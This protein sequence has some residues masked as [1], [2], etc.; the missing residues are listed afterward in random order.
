MKK[1]SL[2]CTLD[3]FD[4]CKFNVYVDEN[5]VIKIEGDKE[6]PYT[7]GFICK[8][9]LMH[10]DRTNHSER[11]YSP[12]L[13]VDGKWQ[14]ISFN[15]AIELMAQKLGM[16]KEAYGSKSILYYEQ[17]GSGSVLKSI[18]DVFFNFFGGVSKQKGGPCWSAGIAAQN[19]NFGDVRSHA[20]EDML[21]S[22]TIIVWGKNP[23]HTTIH[24]MQMIKKAKQQGSYVIVIDPI[25]TAT[26]TQADKYIRIKAGGDGALALAMAKKII[27]KNLYNKEYIS[28]YVNG[29][30]AYRDYV[31]TFNMEKL[32]E[33]AGVTEAE[34][35]FL[36]EKY[37]DF[38]ATILLGYGLQKYAYGGNTIWLIDALA[39][40]TGQIG[41]S[42]GGVN[43]ANKVYP[44]VLNLDPYNSESY[45]D[46]RA[47]YVSHISDFIR[48]NAIKMAV[49]TKSNLLNQLPDLRSLEEAL[50][51]IEF[52]VCFDLFLTDTAQVCDL[53][54]PTTTVLESED[55]L[56]SSM[57]NP[58]ITY[59]EKALEPKEALM[60]EYAFY[61]ALAMKLELK[62]YPQVSKREYLDKVIEPLKEK[63]EEMSLEYLINHYFTLHESIAWKD[64]VF[65]TPSGK[66]E[67]LFN[68]DAFT[69]E[70]KQN[71][72]QRDN[73]FRLLTN[74]SR[75]S[76]FSQHFM[77]RDGIAKA[78][79]N[80]KMAKRHE[81]ED[82]EIIYLESEKGAI[83]VKLEIDDHIG[84]HIVMMYVGWWKKHGNPNWI[85]E[86]GISDIGGQVTYNE[87]F[88]RLKGRDK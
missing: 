31:E 58:Y 25:C 27:E 73:Q 59:N 69:E 42:G 16:Y 77:D 63:H 72:G 84:D 85:T 12:L 23:A 55:L 46:N 22:K 83:Q 71:H 52:K 86:S 1:L 35:D 28:K 37:T 45:A 76:L 26:A 74:H 9:G 67:I 19:Q 44:S 14:E 33:K 20:L 51:K 79:I 78:Y 3:C 64:K 41:V 68:K 80:S 49:I 48:E 6:H 18:G 7:K 82:G 11:Q 66:F 56:F 60:D 54:I 47:F 75:D 24:T 70:D 8:K 34:V 81:F 21:N 62:D 43:Y 36:V 61:R 65:L 50:Q 32:C 38:Y 4:C 57:T 30:E 88:V 13:K 40:L 5:Q 29:F 2:G 87:T 15:Q 17:Y 10:L 39:A 53:F